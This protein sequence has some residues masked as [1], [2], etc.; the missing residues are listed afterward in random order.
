MTLD[1]MIF[2][3]NKLY[4][5]KKMEKMINMEYNPIKKKLVRKCEPGTIRSPDFKCIHP[6]IQAKRS[7]SRSSSSKKLKKRSKTMRS[8]SKTKVKMTRKV[9]RRR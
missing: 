6:K 9:K 7:K 4:D 8:K 2:M 5:L 3:I 1:D